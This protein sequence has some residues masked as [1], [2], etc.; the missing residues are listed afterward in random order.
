MFSNDCFLYIK[1]PNGRV[2]ISVD[3][4]GLIPGTNNNHGF[5]VHTL[6]IN[7]TSENVTIS[8]IFKIN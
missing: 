7:S 4:S 8:M 2:K 5:H 1:R 3:I 6:G